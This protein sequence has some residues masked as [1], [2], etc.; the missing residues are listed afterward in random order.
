MT[1]GTER[2]GAAWVADLFVTTGLIVI[3]VCALCFT[4]SATA[5][6]WGYEQ[7]TGVVGVMLLMVVSA[8]CAQRL[9]RLVSR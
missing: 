3:S 8:V 7:V 1:D 4:G 6:L 9:S 2:R 5:M